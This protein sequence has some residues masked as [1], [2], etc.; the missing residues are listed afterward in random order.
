MRQSRRASV[1]RSIDPAQLSL[2][3]AYLRT[4]THTHSK[5]GQTELG[6]VIKPLDTFPA[7]RDVHLT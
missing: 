3:E 4:H 7:T 2:R 5:I 6:R 1:Q